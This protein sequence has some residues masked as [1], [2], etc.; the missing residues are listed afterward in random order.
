M[1]KMSIKSTAKLFIQFLVEKLAFSN[2]STGVYCNLGP[3]FDTHTHTQ[4][5]NKPQTVGK[6]WEKEERIGRAVLP[7]R[8]H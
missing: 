5:Q 1:N 7:K 2:V 8:L 4:S 3:K 6:E